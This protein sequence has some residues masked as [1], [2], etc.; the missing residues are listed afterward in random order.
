MNKQIKPFHFKQFTIEH[1]KC[2]MKVGFDGALLGAWAN[3]ENPNHIL[4][5]GTGSGLIALILRQRFPQ[6]EIT[7]IEPNKNALIQAEINFSNAPFKKNIILI[8]SDLTSFNHST[9]FD[10]ILSNP[11]FFS[12]DTGGLDID[13]NQARQEKFLPLHSLLSKSK[14]L[15]TDSGTFFLIY[16]TWESER[17]LEISRNLNLYICKQTTIYSRKE[18]PSKRTIFEFKL[19]PC[20]TKLADFISGNQDV[21]Y[22]IEYKQ[23][24]K[25]FYTIF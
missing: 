25:Q 14:S 13:R 11:P 19:S 18:K 17:I 8:N 7:A 12:E 24:M 16:P 3:H 5:I 23:L 6:S 20:K 22:S 21:G 15:L 10:V 4:D 1:D 2:A 9:K